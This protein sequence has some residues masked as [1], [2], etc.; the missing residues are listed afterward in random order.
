MVMIVAVVIPL[1]RLVDDGRLGA[2]PCKPSQAPAGIQLP[3]REFGKLGIDGCRIGSRV[4]LRIARF[5]P[6]E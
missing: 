3:V 1:G 6:Y 2:A 5:D 4:R